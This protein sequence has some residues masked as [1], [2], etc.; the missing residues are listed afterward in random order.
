M[1]LAFVSSCRVECGIASYTDY[2][3][4]AL[5]S[6]GHD[7]QIFGMELDDKAAYYGRGTS[8]PYTRCWTRKGEYGSLDRALAAFSPDVVHAQHEFG[9]HSDISA[10]SLWL[11]SQTHPLVVTLHTVPIPGHEQAKSLEWFPRCLSG[12]RVHAIAHQANGVAAL[13]A[14]GVKRT[15]CIPHGSCGPYAPADIVQR[16]TSRERLSLPVSG[17][18][19]AT[20]GFWTKGKRNDQTIAALIRL[21]QRKRLPHGFTFV[22]AGQPMGRESE[23]GMRDAAAVLERAGLADAIRIRP[24]FVDDALM[25]DYYAATDFTV[26]NCGP[27]MYSITGRGH[28]AMAYGS[29]VLAAD[30]PLLEEFR[31]CGMT[32]STLA[33]LEDGIVKLATDAALRVDLSA[34][35]RAFAE[36]TSWARVA[37]MHEKVYEEALT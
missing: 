27:T 32:F 20:V 19:G 11:K 22:I 6:R 25:A 7:V 33:G 18:I 14:Y 3:G 34:K 28:L 29:P 35:A 9:L 1:R 15:H 5:K 23:N 12:L 24:G 10:F 16:V 17:V 36:Q 31:E 8:L 37:E 26:A 2:L 30:V 13:Q 21:L 4:T